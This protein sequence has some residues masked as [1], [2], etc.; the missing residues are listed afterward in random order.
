MPNQCIERGCVSGNAPTPPP[1]A[2]E[3]SEA[4]FQKELEKNPE[5]PAAH[6]NLGTLYLASGKFAEEKTDPGRKGNYQRTGWPEDAKA[7]WT[8]PKVGVP[9]PEGV[10]NK[11]K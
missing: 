5:D 10:P 2:V 6:Y 8:D 1:G 11:P 9:G 4:T 3:V 7:Q